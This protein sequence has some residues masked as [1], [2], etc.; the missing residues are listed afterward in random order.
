MFVQIC[1][2]FGWKR[3]AIVTSSEYIYQMLAD[4]LKK[5]LDILET[6]TSFHVIEP[7]FYDKALDH[8]KLT[9]QQQVV[10]KVKT[11]ARVVILLG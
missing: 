4:T 2:L 11:E 9:K 1:H 5:E 7:V 6:W 10:K 3:V 8:N